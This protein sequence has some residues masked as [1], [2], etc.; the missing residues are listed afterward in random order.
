M[1]RKVILDK[2]SSFQSL[3]P[4][5]FYRIGSSSDKKIC[6]FF[7]C[8]ADFQIQLDSVKK[9]SRNSQSDTKIHSILYAHVFN[10]KLGC[11]IE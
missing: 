4:T 11:S 8:A 9:R 5:N 10:C 7:P 1:Y 2:F 3:Q 6:K